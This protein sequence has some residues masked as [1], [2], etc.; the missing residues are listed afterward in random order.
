MNSSLP[1]KKKS[2][3]YEIRKQVA[4]FENLRKEEKMMKSNT[5]RICWVN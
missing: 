4:S 3:A 1:K 2:S 5:I